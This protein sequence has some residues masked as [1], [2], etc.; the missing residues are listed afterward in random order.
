MAGSQ[1]DMYAWK[2]GRILCIH[3]DRQQNYIWMIDRQKDMHNHDRQ[4]NDKNTFKKDKQGEWH[5]NIINDGH[6]DM[7]W[8]TT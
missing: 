4:Q 2:A 8:Q 6:E 1:N 3:I 5:A 7:Q